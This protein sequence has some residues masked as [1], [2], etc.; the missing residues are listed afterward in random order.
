[1]HL[2]LKL[3]N[4]LIILIFL[5]SY[6]PAIANNILV[7]NISLTGQ[8][9]TSDYT[10]VEFDISWDN[11]WLDI[12]NWDAAWVFV[13]YKGSDSLWKHANLDIDDAEHTAP[14][15][16]VINTG[17]TDSYAPGVFIYRDAIG[18]GSND[19]DNVQLRWNYGENGLDDN[20]LVTIKVFAIEMVYVPQASFSLGDG[21]D[22]S[23]QYHFYDAGNGPSLP[24]TVNAQSAITIAPSGLGNLWAY[25][26]IHEGT[27]DADFPTGYNAFY[28]M[29]YEITQE[30]YVDFLNTLTRTQQNTR[31][32][33]DISDTPITNRYV[34]SNSSTMSLRNG[35]RCDAA[36]P[37]SDPITFYCDYDGDGNGNETNDGQNIACDYLSWMDGCAYA[38]W[39]GLRPMTELEFEKA[40]RGD[41]TA[42]AGEYAWGNTNIHSS[43]YTLN[44]TGS[45]NEVINGQLMGTG[46]ASYTTTDGSIN[47]PLRSGIFALGSTSRQEAGASYYGIMELSGNL[48]ERAVTI[49]VWGYSFTGNHGG[50]VLSATGNASMVA[51]WPGWDGNEVTGADGAGMRGGSFIYGVEYLCVSVRI[52]AA[53]YDTS[54]FCGYGFRCVRSAQ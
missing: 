2:N 13:K 25:D 18:S 6:Y 23:T 41:Q 35:I 5:L 51:S 34:M 53:Y 27:S 47:G 20:D 15:G 38:C 49:H 11:S 33:T 30:Q 46:N 1:M 10:M 44:N 21:S 36:L 37:T 3:Q 19:W 12:V 4:V 43:A 26:Q 40:C 39:A 7:E 22:L 52:D 45:Y 42:V 50:G 32:Y 54:R 29:K 14:A 31:T 24:F 9:T 48:C 16:S 8:N 17:I 28:C